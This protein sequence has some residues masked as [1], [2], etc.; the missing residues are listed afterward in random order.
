MGVLA[1]S[2]QIAD[3]IGSVSLSAFSNDRGNQRPSVGRLGRTRM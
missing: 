2:F 3:A 1:L